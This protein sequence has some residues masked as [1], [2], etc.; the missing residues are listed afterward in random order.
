MR[1]PNPDGGSRDVSTLT[2]REREVLPYLAG[3]KSNEEIGRILGISGRT[4]EEH[5]AAILKKTGC[6]NR[7]LLIATMLTSDSQSPTTNDP[8]PQR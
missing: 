1:P 2:R 7:K 4:V 3:G 8:K 5:V 6:E